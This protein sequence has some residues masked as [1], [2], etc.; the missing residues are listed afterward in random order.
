[1]VRLWRDV[2]SVLLVIG[3][4]ALVAGFVVP[5]SWGAGPAPGT[6]ANP[7]RVASPSPTESSR[8]LSLAESSLARGAGPAA[9]MPLVCP[10]LLSSTVRCSLARPAAT[11]SASGVGTWSNVTTL[12]GAGPSPR[13]PTMVWD[14]SDGY[15]L[16]VGGLGCGGVCFISDTWTF[17]NGA[18]TNITT[19]VS[20]SP[21]S[22]Y[23]PGLAFDPST[24]KVIFFGGVNRTL[25]TQSATWSYHA[26]AWV[27]LSATVVS[28]PPARVAPA[29]STDSTD[30]EIVMTGGETV[31]G[32]G[33][34]TTTWVFHAGSWTND[35]SI[36]GSSGGLVLPASSDFP[37]ANGV[38]LVGAEFGNHTHVATLEYYSGTWH[39]L[40]SS[41]ST[42]VSPFQLAQAVYSPSARAVVLFSGFLYN[43]TGSTLA[44]QITW[45]FASGA[46]TNL[47]D[48]TGSQPATNLGMAMVVDPSSGAIV[49]FGG[50][51]SI[52][53]LLSQYTYVL[54]S[55]PSVSANASR[56]V[57]DAGMA[58]TFTATFT[59]GIAPDSV[60]WN[61]AD[62]SA[63]ATTAIASH[64]YSR[65][66]LYFVTASVTSFVGS[67]GT[68][69]TAVYV[70]PALAASASV[71]GSSTAGSATAFSVSVTGGTAPFTYAWS[72]GDSSSSSTSTAAGPSHTYSAG[73][74][75][76][77]TVRVTDSVGSGV[78]ATVAVPVAS[79]PSPL[80]SLVLVLVVLLLRKPKN[81]VMMAPVPPGVYMTTSPPPPPAA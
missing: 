34:S 70:N 4:V 40:T 72:F 29:M 43:R 56:S 68:G 31:L 16:L 39:N 23:L 41:L 7:Y 54:S 15:V 71:V 60:V 50:Q 32:G 67:T 19:T 63:S 28:T 27:N 3:L 10:S 55:P 53:P 80:A 13:V 77:A 79:A 42:S 6:N 1:M 76:T 22:V 21:P 12:V 64:S 58:D 47:T 2:E 24:G 20:G 61:F 44:M 49:L 33:Y 75:F 37:P 45:E 18:W 66:G 30:G 38:L 59:G 9:G 65:T 11:G 62:G 14:A 17:V 46:W 25:A 81:P 36:A 48:L 69:S 74:T 5:P 51:R 73:G 78:N 52:A 8:Q 26:K 35:T 57:V